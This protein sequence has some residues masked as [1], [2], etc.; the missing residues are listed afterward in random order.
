[1]H[2]EEAMPTAHINDIDIYYEIQGEGEPLLLICG[3]GADLTSWFELMPHLVA[4]HSVIAFDNRGAGRS[5][6]PDI[7]YSMELFCDDAAGLLDVLAIERAHVLGISMGGMIGQNFGILYPERIISL[8]LGCTRPGGTHS[9][10]EDE[11]T[12]AHMEPE[13]IEEMSQEERFRS[14]LPYLWGQEF[15]DTHPDL[16]EEFIRLRLEYP[17]DP[18]GYARQIAAADAHDVWDRL[19]QITAPTLVIHG[20]ED[21]LIPA[22]NGRRIASQIPGAE[23]VVMEGL[24]HGFADEKPA[25]VATILNDFMGRHAVS[26]QLP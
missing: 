10:L 12:R 8:M 16:I 25:E 26:R 5:E 23:L 18:V 20:S 3:L 9:I 4:G 22:E 21:K 6:K 19:P 24:G 17:A 11:E 15:I 7:P 13:R 1:M 2:R 14:M